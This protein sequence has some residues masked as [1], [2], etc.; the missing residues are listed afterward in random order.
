MFQKYRKEHTA[1]W[2][3][4]LF[5]SSVKAFG[6]R[7]G[8]YGCW[9]RSEGAVLSPR[10]LTEAGNVSSSCGVLGAFA[11]LRKANISFM[12]VSLSLCPWSDSATTGRIS[13][14]FIFVYFLICRGNS[15]FI[16]ILQVEQVFHMKI[17]IHFWSYLAQFFL[18]WEMFQTKVVEKIKTHILYSVTPFFKKKSF[19]LWDNVENIV[20]PD[21]PRMT[22]WRMRISCWIPKTTNTHSEYVMLIAYP[23]QQR[24]YEGG[25]V[26]HYTSSSFPYSW[27]TRR[28]TNTESK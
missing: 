8:G 21:R 18:E 16:N 3:L 10:C 6:W 19:R 11:R 9:I 28:S 12:S 4:D 27:N 17:N 20:Q 14:N 23:L 13:W 15:S 24:S 5:L 25:S 7:G 1:L 26:L 2:E 22:T